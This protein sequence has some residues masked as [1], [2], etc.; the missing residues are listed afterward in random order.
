MQ[1]LNQIKNLRRSS[2]MTT[3]P[4]PV[5]TPEDEAY[6]REVTGQSESAPIPTDQNDQTPTESP[7]G[8]SLQPAMSG[9]AENIPL[10]TSPVE[11]LARRVDK[12]GRALSQHWQDQKHRS[13]KTQSLHRRRNGGVR[14]FGRR[15]QRRS[16]VYLIVSIFGTWHL[17]QYVLICEFPQI[18]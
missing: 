2:Q 12:N 7:A 16:V 8:T 18:G 11:S 1:Y 13:R 5:L 10:P 17:L 4:K 15:T 14:C 9:Q 3:A 6:L